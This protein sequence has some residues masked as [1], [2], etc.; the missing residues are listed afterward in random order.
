MKKHTIII[1][2]NDDLQVS[3]GDI[4]DCFGWNDLKT[5][6]VL[7]KPNMLRAA[8]P[9]ECVVTDPRLIE[10][11]V[12]FLMMAGAEVMVG[13]NPMPDTRF[14]NVNDVADYCGF[15][16]ASR[17]T[18]RNIGRYAR[19][20]KR[21]KNLL[22]EFYVSREV[23][24]CDLLVSLPKY[25]S[26]ELI[27]MTMAVK[28]H[29]GIIPGGLKP[30]IHSLFPNIEEFSRVLVEIYETRV[31]DIIIVDCHDVVDAKG[32]R[33]RPGTLV[34]GD[35]GHAVDFV[36][37]LMAGINPLRV[38]TIRI[39]RDAGLFDPEMIT[40][41]GALRRI[42][43]FGLPL[44]FP[45]RSTVVEFVA[46]ILYRIWLGRIPVIDPAACT[47]CL[48]CE[49]VCPPRAINGQHIDYNKCIKCYC[50]VEVCPSRAI[51]NKARL[52]GRY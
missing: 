34:A 49:N 27:T 48:S 6:R 32:R 18:F 33:H 10:E 7:V 39:A 22:K 47:K 15:T 30:Y 12:S 1:N 45:F 23:F 29:F 20:V 4:F 9:D 41:I 52:I 46:R 35:N 8:C 16:E 50:C 36:C 43:G 42:N 21:P 3:V 26:H 2:H 13:D 40:Y 37:A 5:K 19:K 38:P 24:D 14:P 25:K 44:V 31:P 51:R 17:G 28:N 11:T